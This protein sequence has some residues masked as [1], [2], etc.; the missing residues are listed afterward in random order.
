MSMARLI[1]WFTRS[2]L[3]WCC[4]YWSHRSMS[5]RHCAHWWMWYF[6]WGVRLLA[7]LK[8]GYPRQPELKKLKKTCRTHAYS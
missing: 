4:T 5:Y 2:S 3:R 8:T 7:L 6:L 1:V